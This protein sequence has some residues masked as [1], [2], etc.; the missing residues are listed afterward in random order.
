M[1]PVKKK[2]TIEVQ[3]LIHVTIIHR[4]SEVVQNF[5][6]ITQVIEP[7]NSKGQ[8]VTSANKLCCADH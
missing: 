6:N 2:S 4:C 8:Y 1:K 3:K 7:A 5:T